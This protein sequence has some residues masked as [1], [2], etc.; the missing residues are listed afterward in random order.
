MK[1]LVIIIPCYNEEK[2][3]PETIKQLTTYFKQLI[4]KNLINQKSFICFVDDGSKDNSWEIIQE[5]STNPYIKGIKLSNNFGHQNAL[6]AGL[7]SNHKYADIFITIDCDLQ[8][9][10]N[11]IEQMILEN[12]NGSEIVYAVRKS[13]ES[14]TVFKRKSAEL[15]YDIQLALKIN[16]IKNHADFRLISKKVLKHLKKYKEVNLY[17]R[18]TFPIIGF[19]SSKVYYDRQERFAGETKY[20]LS[21]MLSFAWNGITS[22]TTFPLK[23]ITISGFFIFVISIIMVFYILFIKAFTMDAVPGWAS[24]TLPIYFIGGVQLLSLGII[25]EYIGKIYKETKKRPKYIIEK[26]TQKKD[27]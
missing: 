5:N 10:I 6:L 12:I 22:F 21:K 7:F 25:G 24:T 2:V 20:P 9:D 19:K 16:I 4:D 14:D 26:T 15:F 18:A 3:L 8:D 17:L 1:K 27:E 13:R 11:I 23:M